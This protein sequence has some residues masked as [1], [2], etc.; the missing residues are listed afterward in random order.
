M[1]FGESMFARRT[2]ASKIALAALVA[3]CRGQDVRWIDCQQDTA[4]LAS[5][6]A[7]TVSRSEFE[8]ELARAVPA[9]PSLRWHYD[10]RHWRALGLLIDGPAPLQP[11]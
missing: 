1:V 2:D 9:T 3:L 6:G 8:V 5:L 10:Q 7:H 4:H 11:P